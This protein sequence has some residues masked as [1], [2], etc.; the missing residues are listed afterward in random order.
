MEKV[1]ELQKTIGCRFCMEI[2]IDEEAHSCTL[3]GIGKAL[4]VMRGTGSIKEKKDAWRALQWAEQHRFEGFLA[5]MEKRFPP[6]VV[7]KLIQEVLLERI[8]GIQR[9][10]EREF[11]RYTDLIRAGKTLAERRAMLDKRRMEWCDKR[12]AETRE[13]LKYFHPRPWRDFMVDGDAEFVKAIGVR[14][15]MRIAVDDA[16]YI[17]KKK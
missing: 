12:E 4:E 8:A 16:Y 6:A 3:A 15:F 5:G 17:I 10:R 7:R 14:G 13:V 2:Y 11:A 9:M 1:E